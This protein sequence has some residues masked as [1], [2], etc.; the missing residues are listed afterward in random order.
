MFSTPRHIFHRASAASGQPLSVVQSRLTDE[1]NSAA[2]RHPAM[3][4]LDISPVH[5]RHCICDRCSLHRAA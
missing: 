3:R 5:G 1:M 4:G 2:H